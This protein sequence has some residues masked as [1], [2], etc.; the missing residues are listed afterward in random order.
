M[1]WSV[2]EN[3]SHIQ[4]LRRKRYQAHLCVVQTASGR[5]VPDSTI[6][7]VYGARK[8]KQRKDDVA[9]SWILIPWWLVR[10]LGKSYGCVTLNMSMTTHIIGVT[11]ENMISSVH[12][13]VFA[14]WFS[15][16]LQFLFLYDMSESCGSRLWRHYF[17]TGRADGR[18][19]LLI[20]LLLLC[21]C[22][23][24]IHTM[25]FLS[26]SDSSSLSIRWW[27]SC[28]EGLSD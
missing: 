6:I 18:T 25:L 12:V 15:A 21:C 23:V 8:D 1:R 3:V 16:E 2:L 14:Q 10:L 5:K 24:G 28:W 7:Q 19:L 22:R 20:S 11:R 17:S 13:F 9:F 26:M 4:T 27:H